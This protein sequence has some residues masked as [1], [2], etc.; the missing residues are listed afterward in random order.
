MVA[1]QSVRV[2]NNS[3]LTDINKY[4]LSA[5]STDVIREVLGWHAGRTVILKATQESI[6]M[7]FQ[8]L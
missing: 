5:H 2:L 3:L 4:R 8:L 6:T 1:R 7:T